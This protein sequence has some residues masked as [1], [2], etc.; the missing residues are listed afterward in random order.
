MSCADSHFMEPDGW[1]RVA[2]VGPLRRI[3]TGWWGSDT[4]AGFWSV[5]T[6]LLQSR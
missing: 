6:T 2:L 1:R 3:T 5:G 4:R